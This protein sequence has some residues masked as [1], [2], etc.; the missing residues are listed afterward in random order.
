LCTVNEVET[1]GHTT[2]VKL[3]TK[4]EKPVSV[5]DDDVVSLDVLMP[6]TK[7][8][9]RVKTVL[10]NSVQLYFGKDIFAYIGQYNL[11]HPLSTYKPDIIITGTLLYTKP[12]KKVAWFSE[13]DD[14]FLEKEKLRI[15]D[16]IEKAEVVY[17]D[18]SGA[19]FKLSESG[20]R[21]YV[22]FRNIKVPVERIEIVFK[23]GS[24]HKC[25][26]F[27]YNWIEYIYVCTTDI[28]DKEIF[29]SKWNKGECDIV[30]K[31]ASEHFVTEP[32]TKDTQE[33]KRKRVSES[34]D[35]D[36][37]NPPK[38]ALREVPKKA[39]TYEMYMHMLN[40]DVEAWKTE[41]EKF[42]EKVI[43]KLSQ[44]YQTL[45]ECSTPLQ[46]N[47]IYKKLNQIVERPYA[48]VVESRRLA[49]SC[50]VDCLK[51]SKDVENILDK[52]I[53]LFSYTK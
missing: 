25:R 26:V 48:S 40:V 42:N 52:Y 22:P 32:S 50:Y 43:D 34:H 39:N 35:V 53:S 28:N 27:A 10:N 47:D 33:L 19:F 31:S 29:P 30:P 15:G 41:F 4:E 44:D 49:E 2:V 36:L 8:L 12:V 5:D 38:K 16:I 14:T 18:I 17:R 7:F 24:I 3:S 21:G 20:L 23:E 6:G 13:L 9:L 11:K 37:A 46:A 45:I 51:K 1:I